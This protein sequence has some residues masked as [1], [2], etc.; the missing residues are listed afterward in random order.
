VKKKDTRLWDL[1]GGSREEMLDW[2]AAIE[3]CMLMR[4]QH[5]RTQQAMQTQANN[6][7]VLAG[8]PASSRNLRAVRTSATAT[9]TKK[10]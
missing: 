5:L 8:R 2:V 6:P 1:Q 10:P 3:Q 9:T 7:N 4:R